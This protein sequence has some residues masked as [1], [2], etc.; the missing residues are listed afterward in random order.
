MEDFEHERPSEADELE[1]M[2]R[3]RSK[4]YQSQPDN[5]TTVSQCTC[6]PSSPIDKS[7]LVAEIPGQRRS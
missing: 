1:D 7:W 4:E 2:C 6:I 3:K 5:S